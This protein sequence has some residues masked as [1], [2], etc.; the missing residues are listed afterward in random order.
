[1]DRYWIWTSSS[2]NK[3]TKKERKGIRS[4]ITIH[5]RH[6]FDS[7]PFIHQLIKSIFFLL[8][9]PGDK[10]HA[11]E[12]C[13]KK[14]ALA[15]NLR[16]HLKTHE[17]ESHLSDWTIEERFSKN[18]SLLFL[19]Q[20]GDPQDECVRCGKQY[21]LSSNELNQGYCVKCLKGVLDHDNSD[22]MGNDRIS[23]SS[24][25]NA[26]HSSAESGPEDHSSPE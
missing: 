9:L 18:L 20:T 21:L 26:S 5:V 10:P 4:A 8:H 14:F 13:N 25:I 11:C 6:S 15:C 12:L 16:A 19:P 3:S 24:S 7:F 22:E 17:G 1:M 2:R 23:T